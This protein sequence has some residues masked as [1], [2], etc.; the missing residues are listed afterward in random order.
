VRVCE[1]CGGEEEVETQTRQPSQTQTQTKLRRCR[2]C[3]CVVSLKEVCVYYCRTGKRRSQGLVSVFR[4]YRSVFRVLPAKPVA[5]GNLI[6]G[7]SGRTSL[8]FGCCARSRRALPFPHAVHTPAT[9]V[10]NRC[11]PRNRLIPTRFWHIMHGRSN[12]RPPT[13][14][15]P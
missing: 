13:T 8:F 5:D 11:A 4:P 10:C 1:G 3:V 9:A 15:A 7:W 6:Q 2:V 12:A 14:L